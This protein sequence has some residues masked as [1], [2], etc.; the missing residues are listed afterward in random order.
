MNR[1]LL[2]PLARPACWLLL[3]SPALGLLALA[4]GDGL[5]PNPAE[6]LI[7]QLGD[8]TLRALCLTLAITPLRQAL[9]WTALARFRRAAGVATFAYGSL[10]W[11]AYAWLD[12]G[13][14]LHALWTDVAKR[15][16]ILVGTAAWL[17]MVPLAA[18]S[19]DAAVRR[20]G[21]AAWRRLHRL[22]YL[23]APLA[24]LHFWWMRAGKNNLAEVGVYTLLLAGLLLWRVRPRGR[25]APPPQAE[26]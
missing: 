8:W 26:M 12:Q 6:A 5:G 9:G 14:D 18:T 11:L 23:L 20:L 1:L 17:T 25:R 3:A 7:R 2:H 16:F 24:L 15:P 4:L 10:H 22:C 19:V 21:G 13:L